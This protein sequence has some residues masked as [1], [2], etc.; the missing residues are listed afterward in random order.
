[1]FWGKIH[2]GAQTDLFKQL[3]M[4]YKKGIALLF[5]S[6]SIRSYIIDILC[7][8]RTTV[9]TDEHTLISDSVFNLKLVHEIES[10]LVHQ[11]E[12]NLVGSVIDLKDVEQFI[13]LPLTWSLS[14][15]L[16]TK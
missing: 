2:S 15:S 3:Y 7:N 1:M 11:S 5:H 6:P 14:I 4:L 12:A 8:L 10:T 16:V 13:G 9:C